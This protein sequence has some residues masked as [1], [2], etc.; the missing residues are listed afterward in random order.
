MPVN[1]FTLK[2]FTLN[3][4]PEFIL[5]L[6]QAA[7]MMPSKKMDPEIRELS[8]LLSGLMRSKQKG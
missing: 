7:L 2:I 1:V 3:Y 8:A 5:E 6:T 4:E